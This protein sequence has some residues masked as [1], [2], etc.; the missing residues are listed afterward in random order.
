MTFYGDETEQDYIAVISYEKGTYYGELYLCDKD[1]V[2][3]NEI[4]RRNG[5][6]IE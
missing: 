5:K 2:Q 1:I 3:Q 4:K 6:E